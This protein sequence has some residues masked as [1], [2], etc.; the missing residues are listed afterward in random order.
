MFGRDPDIDI[1]VKVEHFSDRNQYAIF[2][3]DG[4]EHH[5]VYEKVLVVLDGIYIKPMETSG[6]GQIAVGVSAPKDVGIEV[7]GKV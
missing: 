2:E 7:G 1:T 3:L 4:K 5:V 6:Y